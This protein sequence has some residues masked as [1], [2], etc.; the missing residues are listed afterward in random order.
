MV[1]CAGRMGVGVQSFQVLWYGDHLHLTQS[2]YEKEIL[3]RR[4][5]GQRK[6]DL[7]FPTSRS[8][9][10]FEAVDNISPDTLRE[11]QTLAGGLLWL[12]TRTRPDLAFGVSTMS[13]D[14]QEPAEGFGGWKGSS[15]LHQGQPW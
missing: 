4:R 14:A 11:A 6:G 7:T 13:P 5:D 9:A 15:E 2:G 3:E 1:M 10:D 12:D 8:E